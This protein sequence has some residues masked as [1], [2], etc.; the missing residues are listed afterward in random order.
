M[1]PVGVNSEIIQDGENGFL[2]SQVDE[3]VEKL[4]KLIEDDELRA[5]PPT[6]LELFANV[7]RNYFRLYLNYMYFNVARGLYIQADNIFSYVLLIPTIAAGAITFGLLQQ[8]L[9]AFNQV[10]NSFQFLVNSWST[11]IEL[12]SIHKRLRAFE[13][14]LDGEEQSSIEFEDP[15]A[16]V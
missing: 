2:A 5:Q 11:I 13:K 4:S 7:R 3:W 16:P 10:S 6:L 1:S 14:T 12:M 9:T 15:N 8:I